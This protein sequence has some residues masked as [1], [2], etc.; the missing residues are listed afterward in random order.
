MIT[1]LMYVWLGGT[2]PLSIDTQTIEALAKESPGC[3]V[4]TKTH[5]YWVT[6][7]CEQVNDL[8]RRAK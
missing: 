3:L 5:Q 7:T 6:E 1:L 4:Y 8:I 2:T